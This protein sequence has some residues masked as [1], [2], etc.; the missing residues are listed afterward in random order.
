[1]PQRIDTLR[2]LH[3]DDDEIDQEMVR[4]CLA[5]RGD[6]TIHQVSSIAAIRDAV[7][8]HGSDIVLLD[9]NLDGLRGTASVERV[10]ELGID[11]PIVVVTGMDDA[12]GLHAIEAGA[13]DYVPKEDMHPQRV[14]RTL[15]HAVARWRL[16]RYD[17]DETEPFHRRYAI[18][19]V[20]GRG[21][22]TVAYRVR[23]RTLQSLHTLKFLGPEDQ[24]RH[25][26]LLREGRIQAQLN[27][28]HL[29][30]VTDVLT[31]CRE[32]GLVLEHVDGVPL[33]EW[34]A[35][36]EHVQSDWLDLVRGLARGLRAAHRAGYVHGDLSPACVLVERGTRPVAK[37]GG[38]GALGPTP[39][40]VDDDCLG[41][42]APERAAG[43]D[44]GPRADLFSLG[45]LLF[46]LACGTPA[47]RG[48]TP[49]ETRKL[50][51][52][53]RHAE[54]QLLNPR[55]PTG[56]A[57]TIEQLLRPDP[58]QRPPDCDALLDAL[59]PHRTPGP[60]PRDLA[61]RTPEVTATVW[62]GTD[63]ELQRPQ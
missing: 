45:C 27:H 13:Q 47:F 30:R 35:A 21:R 25:A 63:P 31:T 8:L 3:V 12:V 49:G 20:I 38:F 28:P 9:L 37:I 5:R 55:V 10:L 24:P 1:M 61:A 62:M 26:R 48:A 18:E 15:T 6:V 50:V 16:Q 52:L 42:V 51:Q 36:G 41:Y 11:L 60:S 4:R 57:R 23:H 54:V 14:W 40:P 19:A 22:A 59:A 33:R 43:R 56:L 53:G 17:D 39:S 34:M 32:V 29:V 7:E 58:A 46:E 2:I 44:V